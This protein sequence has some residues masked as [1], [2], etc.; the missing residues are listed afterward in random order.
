MRRSSRVFGFVIVVLLGCLCLLGITGSG[1][2]YLYNALRAA[3]SGSAQA[4]TSAHPMATR[5]TPLSTSSLLTPVVGS[6]LAFCETAPA[7]AFDTLDLLTRTEPAAG[8]R[9]EQAQRLQGIADI[10]R[11][12]AEGAAPVSTGTRASF[13]ITNMDTDLQSTVTAVMRYA[14]PHVYFWVEEGL[15][16]DIESIRT[17]VDLFEEKIYPA[18]REFFGSEWTPGIDGD[19][20]LYI[21]YARGLGNGIGGYFSST[22]EVPRQAHPNSNEHEMFYLNADAVLLSPAYAGGILAHE[23]QHMI[24]WKADH[25]EDS[26][27]NEGFAELA[28]LRNGFNLGGFDW[29][30]LSRTDIQ[31]NDWPPVTDY[32]SIYHYGGSFLFVEYF[33]SRFGEDA[34]R[35][36]VRNT[37]NGMAGIDDTLRSFGASDPVSGR[38][39]TADDVMSDFAVA[40]LLDDPALED[41][42]YDF[43]DYEVP[44]EPSMAETFSTC[45]TGIIERTPLEY[46]IEY[47]NIGCSGDWRVSFAGQ[48]TQKALPVD[49]VEGVY[50]AWSNRGDESDMT[51]TRAFDLPD[52]APATLEYSLWFDIEKDYDFAYLEISTDDGESWTVL[53]PPSAAVSFMNANSFGPG[54]TGT[55]GGSTA[56]WIDEKVDLTPYAGKRVLVRFEYITDLAQ[57]EEG[58]LVDNIRIPEIG[59]AT[60]FED[61]LDGWEA[62]GFVRLQ[63]IL[64]QTFRVRLVRFGDQVTVK[65]I[66]LDDTMSGEL[67]LS[68]QAGEHAVLVVVPITR[69]TNQTTYY[70]MEIKTGSAP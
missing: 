24:H 47:V 18:N 23:F 68:L 15:S 37:K 66:V 38:P 49:P 69:Y 48:T 3:N 36:L 45:P 8:D 58:L 65:D 51:L 41:G 6:S 63:N 16:P 44:Q 46:S 12:P 14:T 67:T 26:W 13:S 42:R 25:N 29:L 57:N 50:Y 7:A 40:L 5:R 11:V 33:F 10:P 70:R 27:L 30:Y 34:T 9:I 55:N 4:T 39:L 54:W 28:V 22:D 19:P 20:H 17:L 21:L 56:Q 52:G 2:Q 31:L 43:T 62:N 59:Y 32:R 35:A 61:G 1:A 53:H 64:P 60:G